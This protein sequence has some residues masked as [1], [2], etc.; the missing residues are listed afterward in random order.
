MRFDRCVICDY[1][2][3]GGSFYS[4]AD[5][6]SNRVRYNEDTDEF[7]C[8][9]CEGFISEAVGEFPEDENDEKPTE[10]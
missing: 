9:Q 2:E 10:E 5:P 6:S 7:L 3:A 1:T 8:T 4:G